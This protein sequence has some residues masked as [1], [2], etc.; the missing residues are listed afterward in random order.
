MTDEFPDLE[1]DLR[2]FAPAVPAG[3]LAD[4][5]SRELAASPRSL[6]SDRCL[7]GAIAMGLAASIV[8]AT[9]LGSDWFEGRS[10]RV[11]TAAV[12]APMIVQTRELLTQLALGHESPLWPSATAPN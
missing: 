9:L 1:A 6:W 5:I 7:T 3:N 2:R 4:R 12:E 10:S 11:P 8:I